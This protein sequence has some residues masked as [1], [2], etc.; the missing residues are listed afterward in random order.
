M[1]RESSIKH[2][3]DI[4]FFISHENV[5]FANMGLLCELEERDGVDLGQGYKNDKA[6]AS[7]VD[8]TG[9]ENVCVRMNVRS[10]LACYRE[11]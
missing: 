6:C 1:P 5:A 2:K 7:F 8:Y 9:R 3:F 4:A 10:I 11:H